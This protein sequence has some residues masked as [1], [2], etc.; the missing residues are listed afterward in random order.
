MNWFQKV[1]ETNQCFYLRQ[2]CNLRLRLRLRLTMTTGPPLRWPP[3][4]PNPRPLCQSTARTAACTRA[5]S[6]NAEPSMAK[7]PSRP[8]CT[9]T[10]VLETT[11]RMCSDGPNTRGTGPT[12]CC[13]DK[14][15]CDTCPAMKSCKW[16]M[17]AC[18]ATAFPCNHFIKVIKERYSRQTP[19]PTKTKT[20][21]NIF[22]VKM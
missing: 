19:K 13:T 4:P 10:A 21:K 6:T 18:G 22:F 7:A 15:S 5:M 3:N 16:C 17:T 2:R 8:R 20:K 1:F 14:V 9:C 11:T 12:E